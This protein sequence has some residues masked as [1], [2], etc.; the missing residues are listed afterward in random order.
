[1]DAAVAGQMASLVSAY[2]F[3]LSTTQHNMMLLI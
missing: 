1:M 2:I 3:T